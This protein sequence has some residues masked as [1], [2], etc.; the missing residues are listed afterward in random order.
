MEDAY[1]VIASQDYDKAN[2]K[3]LWGANCKTD[4]T[5]DGCG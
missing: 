4:T 5:A 3:L 1:V 2:H